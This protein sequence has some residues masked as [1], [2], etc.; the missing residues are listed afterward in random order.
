MKL[1]SYLLNLGFYFGIL[2]LSIGFLGHKMY[3]G[4]AKFSSI[5]V[6]LLFLTPLAFIFSI[7]VFY[8]FKKDFKK[9]LIAFFLLIIF[10]V[11]LFL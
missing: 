9:S 3:T 6:M 10:I 1:I 8:V 5:G 2:L 4:L 11:N 7:I